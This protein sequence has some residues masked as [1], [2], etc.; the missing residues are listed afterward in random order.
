MQSRTNEPEHPPRQARRLLRD[1]ELS[2]EIGIPVDTLRADRINARR[3]PFIKFGR[4][5][6][7]DLDA[8]LAAL[9]QFRMGG[10]ARGGQRSK[11][12]TKGAK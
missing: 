2:A 5:V 12:A 10:D 8:A 9:E 1:Y 4:A 6:W 7:Y 3:I 11:R